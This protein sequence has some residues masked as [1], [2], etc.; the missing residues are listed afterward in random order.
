MARY[1]HTPRQAPLAYLQLSC[2]RCRTTI[3]ATVPAKRTADED[4]PSHRC[5][6]TGHIE[7][8]THGKP[9]PPVTAQQTRSFT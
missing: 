7:P 3:N 6:R 5:P 4:W 2:N 1:G 8:F 9:V